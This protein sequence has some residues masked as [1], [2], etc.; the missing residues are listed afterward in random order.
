[1]LGEK[2]NGELMT[3]SLSNQ[4]TNKVLIIEDLYRSF[5]NIAVVHHLVMNDMKLRYR[6]SLIGPFWI[7]LSLIFMVAGLTIMFGIILKRDLG[8]YLSYI[9]V[10]IIFW[11]YLGSSLMESCGAFTTQKE[12]LQHTRLP[13]ALYIFRVFYRNIIYLGHHILLLMGVYLIFFNSHLNLTIISFFY[14]FLNLLIIL[15]LQALIAAF[16]LRYYDTEPIVQNAIQLL[17]FLSPVIWHVEEISH[18]KLIMYLEQF[19]PFFHIVLSFRGL[20][21]AHYLEYVSLVSILTILFSV[22]F[23]N[24]FVYKNIYK[25][26]TLWV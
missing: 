6:N 23:M 25:K 12:L 5:K 8:D 24:Y 22:I 17:F 21:D 19:N 7:T 3:Y 10:G 20:I 26:I 16:S 9:L 18:H 15:N 4:K 1:M 14:F 2:Q 13:Y 11:S